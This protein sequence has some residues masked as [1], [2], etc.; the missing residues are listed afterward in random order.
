M[1]RSNQEVLLSPTTVITD[2][3]LQGRS[4]C[5]LYSPTEVDRLERPAMRT[6]RWAL[7]ERH[8]GKIRLA[9]DIRARWVAEWKEGW[10]EE[11][12]SAA[13]WKGV[14]RSAAFGRRVY[15]FLLKYEVLHP[16]EPYIL[17]LDRGQ[18]KGE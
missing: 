13:Y 5:N 15:E 3:E 6:I 11:E 16:Y 1:A 18:V 2:Q 8:K 14:N 17:E 7:R 10:G 9:A 4:Q 12:I